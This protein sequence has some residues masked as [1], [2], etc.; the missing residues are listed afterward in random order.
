LHFFRSEKPA[1]TGCGRHTAVGLPIEIRNYLTL[2]LNGASGE[3]PAD[4]FQ[5]QSEFFDSAST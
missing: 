5:R 4:A 3:L 2:G 1:T